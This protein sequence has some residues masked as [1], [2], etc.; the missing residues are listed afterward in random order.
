[1]ALPCVI[2]VAVGLRTGARASADE[3]PPP[4]YDQGV[5]LG[6][7]PPKDV[8]PASDVRSLYLRDC[9]TCHGADAH[10]TARA[11]RIATSGDWRRRRGEGI[12]V[13]EP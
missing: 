9:A 7:L 11:A 3:K 10:G 1:M 8:P 13:E 4:Q 2:G 5:E 12:E 6:P